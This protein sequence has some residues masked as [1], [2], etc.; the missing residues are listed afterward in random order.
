MFS[1]SHLFYVTSS[2][3]PVGGITRRQFGELISATGNT[4]VWAHAAQLIVTDG[5][6]FECSVSPVPVRVS[7]FPLFFLFVAFCFTTP[8]S[9]RRTDE[10]HEKA[11]IIGEEEVSG[12]PLLCCW[13]GPNAFDRRASVSSKKKGER[14]PLHRHPLSAQ[15]AATGAAASD[16]HSGA[17]QPSP[18]MI[19]HTQQRP[20]RQRWLVS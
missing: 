20:A 2:S 11:M 6:C 14:R 16:L 1:F 15:V 10:A 18:P 8:R 12:V 5:L 17:N 13:D 19:G 7:S 9:S 4:S 3:V